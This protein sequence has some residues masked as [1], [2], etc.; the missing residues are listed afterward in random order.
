ML[1]HVNPKK[2]EIYLQDH[3]DRELVDYLVDGYTN[4][5][6]LGV[7]RR[8]KPQLPCK[9]LR[10]A[11]QELEITQ[12]L[13][14]KEVALGH[15]LGPIDEPPLPDMVFSPLNIIP[16]A[17][18]K[19]KYRLIHDLAYPYNSESMNSCIPTEHA[20]IQYHTIDE[21]IDMG[22][23]LR[24][25]TFAG[26]E[27]IEHAFHNQTLRLADLSLLGFTLMANIT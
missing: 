16:K 9:N 23:Q 21:V 22:M 1:R 24:T 20:S 13:V 2:L 25:G 18:S 27:D 10:E 14:D 3:P 8:P 7:E 6:S 15:M 5:F 26:W 19:D 17:G 4:R 12:A 11:C